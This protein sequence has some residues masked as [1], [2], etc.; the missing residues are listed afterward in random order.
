MNMITDPLSCFFTAAVPALM[1][2]AG[3]ASSP[4]MAPVA[5]T[6]PPLFVLPS[7][8]ETR[9]ASF[10]NPSGRKGAGAMENKGAKGHAFHVLEPGEIAT[11]MEHTGSG[12]IRRMWLTLNTRKPEDL[13]ALRLRM[14]WDQ[15][16][17]PAVDVPLGDFFGMVHGQ[18]ITLENALF[19]TGEGRSFNCYI[20]MPFRK[21]ARITMS[22]ETAHPVTLFYDVNYTTGDR[23]DENVLYFHASWRR[24]RYTK[25][26]K[27]FEILPKVQGRGRFLGC[28]VGMLRKEGN[29][30]WWGEGETK[31]YLDGDDAWP[32]LAGTGAEDYIGSAYAVGPFQNR[33]Q[34]FWTSFAYPAYYRYHIPDPVYFRQS[35][36]VTIQQ[37]GGTAKKHVMKMLAEGVEI[38]PVGVNP[39]GSDMIKF[40]ETGES[41][42]DAKYPENTYTLF[43]RR[44][45]VC[46]VALFYL[47]RPTSGLPELAPVAERIVALPA[48]PPPTK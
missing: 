7:G 35:C 26:G 1:L 4:S 2:L 43:Y 9:W 6:S 24:E 18:K 41:I 5:E 3:C 13:R 15:A 38:Q 8:V 25:L 30:G 20:P 22:N 21:G 32:T 34:G 42:S 39:P 40:L 33:F 48:A 47:D 10:E 44:D 17:K 37:L 12:T 19:S 23:H 11:M 31:I 45:D 14:Y 27:D 16:E 28:H 46:A 36:R 29:V